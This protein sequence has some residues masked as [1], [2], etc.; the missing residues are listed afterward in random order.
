MLSF[1]NASMALSEVMVTQ[2]E[3]RLNGERDMASQALF[4]CSEHM[5]AGADAQVDAVHMNVWQEE[6]SAKSVSSRNRCVI[7]DMTTRW[8]G[9]I[10]V[11]ALSYSLWRVRGKVLPVASGV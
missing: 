1:D 5:R 2:L 11:R 6:N 3:N 8:R 4:R 9:V 7:C 10:G